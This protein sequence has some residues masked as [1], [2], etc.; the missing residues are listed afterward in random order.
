MEDSTNK[1]TSTSSLEIELCGGKDVVKKGGTATSTW[2]LIWLL[3]IL[4]FIQTFLSHLSRPLEFTSPRAACKDAYSSTLA[5]HH[6][7]VVSSLVKVALNLVPGSR[8]YMS[9]QFGFPNEVEGIK[10]C[11]ECARELERVIKELE[12]WVRVNVGDVV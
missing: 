11:R 4:R 1:L 3:R 8:D 9:L 12:K 6:S 5:K 2:G 7:F 10:E